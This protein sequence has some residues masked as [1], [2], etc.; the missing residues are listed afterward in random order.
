MRSGRAAPLAAPYRALPAYEAASD[1]F[2]EM[3]SVSRRLGRDREGIGRSLVELTG[4]IL[5]TT[6]EAGARPDPAFRALGY[7]FGWFATHR[8][9]DLMEAARQLRRYPGEAMLSADAVI[10]NAQQKLTLACGAMED[11]AFRPPSSP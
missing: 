3:R 2:R 5:M 9:A 10:R 6:A 7:R 1:L 8:C 11:R 4:R